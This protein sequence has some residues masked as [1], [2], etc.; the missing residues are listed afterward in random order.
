MLRKRVLPVVLVAVA[1]LSAYAVRAT[2][3]PAASAS[4]AAQPVIKGSF[5][6]VIRS[7]GGRLTWYLRDAVSGGPAVRTFVYGEAGDIPVWGDWNG[8]GVPTAG[9]FRSGQW[10]LTDDPTSTNPTSNHIIAY[11]RAGDTPVV[12]NW[13]GRGGTGIGVARGS[14]WLLR[15]SVSSGVAEV[16]YAFGRQGDLPVVGD[17]DG[18]GADEPGVFR[19]G[20]WI[21]R[22]GSG[23]ADTS[24]S[25]MAFGQDG[26][27]P[28]V[29]AWAGGRR[30]TVGVVRGNIW[31]LARADGTPLPVFSFGTPTDTPL[32]GPSGIVTDG[33]AG[34]AAVGLANSRLTKAAPTDAD[35]ERL[36]RIL[37]N[38]N[39]Y[40]M[41]T[42]WSAKGFASQPAPYLAFGG[43][44]EL[45]I[46][47]PAM[48]AL[49][50]ATSLRT[51][52]F[53]PGTAGVSKA[54][55]TRRAVLLVT[56]LAYRHQANSPNGWGSAWESALWA[57]QAG[58]AG[59]LM[60]DQLT[61]AGREY[62]ARMVAA[63][64]DRFIGY[65]VPYYKNRA[66]TIV[67]PGDTKAEENAWNAMVLQLAATMMP[68]NSHAAAWS[69]MEAALM[70]SAFA[71]PSDVDSQTVLNGRT[72]ASWL[73]GSN[74]EPNGFV[75]NHNIIHP[76]YST[77][78]S[79]NLHAAIVYSLAD[80]ATP[81]AALFNADIVYD[82]LVNYSWRAG[83]I[84]PPGGAIHSPGGTV[85]VPGSGSLFYPQ[86]NDWGTDRY[87]QPMT[88]DT[89]ASLL[90]L[91]HGANTPATVWERLHGDKVLAQQDRSADRRTYVG[92]REDVYGGREELV[93]STVA[94]AWLTG[95]VVAQGTYRLTNASM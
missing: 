4:A 45:N 47:P 35:S 5:P 30:D 21:L 49:G 85:Y 77:T 29:G 19:R 63:E 46:R 44:D 50:L 78:V 6:G 12:G 14:T 22:A 40:G 89:Q 62:V 56:S 60:W 20:T 1:I 70:V 37:D 54:E 32:H 93:A 61:P 15:D 84:Y 69:H 10:L 7:A 33:S 8:D 71:R 57:A 26:D 87:I 76:D 86:G 58:L 64:A 88:L 91:D 23:A 16:S 2:I 24:T 92:A 43:V 11:G 51:N 67:S 3:A 53:D 9:V 34:P 42:W 59:W 41:V 38:T 81:K 74:A 80:R 13:D 25:T 55:A 65:P 27:R 95:W 52:V 28:V 48:E 68:T 31:Q 17:W 73:N 36:V 66:G 79:E 90:G 94:E 83:S 72:V 39:R 75:I 18:D 82:A